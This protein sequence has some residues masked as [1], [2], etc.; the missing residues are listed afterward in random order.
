M[1]SSICF[2]NLDQHYLYSVSFSAKKKEKVL[3]AEYLKP[4]FIVKLFTLN[5]TLPFHLQRSVV[6]AVADTVNGRIYHGELFK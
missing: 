4:R 1:L 5:A 2:K 3:L 6:G